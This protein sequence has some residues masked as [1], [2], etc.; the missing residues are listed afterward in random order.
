MQAVQ[1]DVYFPAETSYERYL[2]SGDI[3]LS[4][5][6][7]YFGSVEAESY[8][9]YLVEVPTTFTELF[10]VLTPQFGN[11][12]LLASTTH[13][14]RPH[15]GKAQYASK[16]SVGS[17]FIRI[18]PSDPAVLAACPHT[19]RVGSICRFSVGVY[20]GTASSYVITASTS[21]T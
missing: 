17:E 9:Y 6:A 7:P 12:N 2:A 19:S 21:G 20:G 13:A 1:E 14:G 4:L 18:Y 3:A 10:L 5:G 16:F 11:V 8:A 15:M